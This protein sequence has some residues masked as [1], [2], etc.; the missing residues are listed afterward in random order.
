MDARASRRR[1]VAREVRIVANEP[2]TGR[3]ASAGPASP[4]T[5]IIGTAEGHHAGAFHPTHWLLLALI[6]GCWGST[7]LFVDISLDDLQPGLVAFLRLVLGAAALAVVPGALA[8]LP[9]REW[10]ALTMMA[11]VWLAAPIAVIPIAQQRVDSSF[12]GMMAGAVPLIAALVAA[13]LLRR[14]PARAQAV[15]LLVG[16]AGILAISIP[17]TAGDSASPAGTGLML[18]VILCF[19]VGS[20]LAV[21]LNQRYGALPVVFRAQALSALLLLPWGLVSLDGSHFTLSSTLALVGLALLSG[22]LAL[23]AM[24]VLASRVGA[25]RANIAVYFVPIVAIVLGLLVRDDSVHPVAPLG[26]ALVLVGAYLASR[27]E[28]SHPVAARPQ[29][30]ATETA[31]AGPAPGLG[32]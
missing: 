6:A 17:G 31:P 20:N 5:S 11:V 28:R 14:R 3:T 7:F 18:I 10:P 26:I 21:P 4:A 24:S 27:A 23:V 15:G 32:S 8:P 13:L 29:P 9:R 30:P 16:F 2:V 22:S 19:G 1:P 25:P 12:A